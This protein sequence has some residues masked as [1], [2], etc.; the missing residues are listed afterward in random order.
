MNICIQLS[1]SLVARA[2]KY[3]IDIEYELRKALIT[4]VEEQEAA[5][6]STAPPKPPE[7]SWEPPAV[8]AA[9]LSFMQYAEEQLQLGV[10]SIRTFCEARGLPVD[11]DT[12]NK[13][14][15]VAIERWSIW[16]HFLQ[17]VKLD[18]YNY[19]ATRLDDESHAALH[20][21]SSELPDVHKRASKLHYEILNHPAGT[22]LFARSLINSGTALETNNILQ[23]LKHLVDVGSGAVSHRKVLIEAAPDTYRI[24]ELLDE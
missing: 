1:D 4:M 16:Q 20:K 3:E 23:C 24:V 14:L 21:Y 11:D 2:V 18:G 10:F 17:V 22:V 5:G 8:A 7:N 13:A 19:K 15:R 12:F 9:W 6:G